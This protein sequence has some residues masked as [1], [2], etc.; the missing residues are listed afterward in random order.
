MPIY[1][2]FS[3]DLSV[4]NFDSS[5]NLK[6]DVA[7]SCFVLTIINVFTVLVSKIVKTLNRLFASRCFGAV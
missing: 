2:I 7:S 5:V 6:S 1:C 3:D 4:G